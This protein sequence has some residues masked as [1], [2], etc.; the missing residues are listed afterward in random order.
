[1]H[2]S[3]NSRCSIFPKRRNDGYVGSF[4]VDELAPNFV[5]AVGVLLLAGFVLLSVRSSVAAFQLG[6]AP[7][8]LGRE[9][10]SLTDYQ[11]FVR[12]LLWAVGV[13]LLLLIAAQVLFGQEDLFADGRWI[14]ARS[15]DVDH[16]LSIAEYG[17]QSQGEAALFIVFL[18]L[19]PYLLGAV[20]K[21]TGEYF[22]TGSALS[23]LFLA[24]AGVFLYK[25][26]RAEYGEKAAARA[27]KYIMLFPSVFF[28][29]M[30]MSEGLFLLLAAMFLYYLR[31]G[32]FVLAGALGMLAAFTR[33]TGVILAFP[34]LVELLQTALPGGKGK[35]RRILRKGWPVFLIPLGTL[36][37]LAINYA[38]FADPL[39]FLYVQKSHWSQGFGLFSNTLVYLTQNVLHADVPQA[40]A[41]WLP[42]LLVIFGTLVVMLL[43]SRRQRPMY[44]AYMLAMFYFSAS[45]TW[46]LSMPRYMLAMLPCVIEVARRA[47]TR[48]RDI[49]VT[50]ALAAMLAAFA[51]AF[52]SGLPIY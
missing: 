34:F 9:D 2:G 31:R 12:S 29:G 13:K 40:L 5:A 42:E 6:S 21:F 44:L 49:V 10:G 38:V 3:G 47:R 32:K 26:V 36:A 24:T 35:C 37:Y 4:F 39:R 33:S 25:L 23:L 15:S 18:P 45:A 16:Y 1:M 43:A 14:W 30:P 52:A 7:L 27:L 46:L 19:Y 28:A 50:V 41:L 51:L 20:G 17:Y 48:G 11:I 22:W 8:L